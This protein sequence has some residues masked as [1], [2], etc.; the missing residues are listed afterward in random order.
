M[1]WKPFC[2][3]LL[4]GLALGTI[5]IGLYSCGAAPTTTIAPTPTIPPVPTRIPTPT[6][7]P[8]QLTAQSQFGR[9]SATQQAARE[10]ACR[11]VEAIYHRHGQTFDRTRGVDLVIAEVRVLE[12][13]DDPNI[14]NSR[15][16][17]VLDDNNTAQIRVCLAR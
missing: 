17:A 9:Q 12:G 4:F 1:G 16:G 2:L 14:R 10:T 13:L 8:F 6:L 5:A 11:Y 15:V 3:G 7:A